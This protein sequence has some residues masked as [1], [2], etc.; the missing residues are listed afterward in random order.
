[1][2]V[3]HAMVQVERRGAFWFARLNRPDKRNALSEADDRRIA[4]AVR[5]GRRATSARA[6]WCSGARAD[7]SAPAPTSAASWN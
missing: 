1:M 5:R 6:H 2:S 7:T 4:R 3:Y